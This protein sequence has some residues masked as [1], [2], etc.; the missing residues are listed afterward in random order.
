[1][2]TIVILKPRTFCLHVFGGNKACSTCPHHNSIIRTLQLPSLPRSSAES[3]ITCPYCALLEFRSRCFSVLASAAPRF[4][5]HLGLW[6]ACASPAG[7]TQA[8]HPSTKNSRMPCGEAG[9]ALDYRGAMYT[10]SNESAQS[11]NC[12]LAMK[13]Y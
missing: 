13:G 6:L 8:N 5:S 1:M 12:G 11:E 4:P 10:E 2:Y 9:L 7:G 3:Y